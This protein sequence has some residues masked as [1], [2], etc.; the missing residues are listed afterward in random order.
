[1]PGSQSLACQVDAYGWLVAADG[2]VSGSGITL[3]RSESSSPTTTFASRARTLG[4]TVTTLAPGVAEGMG[5][6]D[7]ELGAGTALM[8]EGTETS[9]VSCGVN[10]AESTGGGLT[11]DRASGLSRD[12]SGF[13]KNTGGWT[14]NQTRAPVR[15]R[16]TGRLRLR[17]VSRGSASWSSSASGSLGTISQLSNL[18]AFRRGPSRIRS[19]TLAKARVHL[20]ARISG[21]S[22]HPASL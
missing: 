4:C 17:G 13:G 21:D 7:T 12:S 19:R 22:S 16:R 8:A 9:L 15:R 6:G 3:K 11:G 1:M 5:A 20:S 14:I 18:L 10:A 2:G